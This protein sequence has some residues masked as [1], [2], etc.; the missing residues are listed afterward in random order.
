MI[1]NVVKG[2]DMAGLVRYLVGPG[3]ANEHTH[4]H[5]IGGDGFV[6]AWHGAEEL[7]RAAAGELAAYLEEPRL[8]YGTEIRSRQ[9]RQ[10]PE[11]GDREPV[12]NE[13]GVQDYRNVHVW[14]C[15][16]SLPAGEVLSDERWEKVTAEFMDE[17][18][19]S[20]ASGKAPA[21]WVAIHHGQSTNGNDH[22][23]IAASMVREDGTRW[24][25]R[26]QDFRRAQQVCREL[27]ARHQLAPVE[28]RQF[29]TATRAPRPVETAIAARNDRPVTAREELAIRLRAAAVAS[30]SEAEWLRRV[31]ADGVV[32]RPRFVAGST[33]VVAGYKA[34]LRTGGGEPLAFYGG[35]QI[36][37]DLSLPRV[38][39]SW[40]APSVVAADQA[41]TEWQA[42]FK[43]RRT[44]VVGREGHRLDVGDQQVAA[45]DLKR[46][47]G[48]LARTPVTE[49]TAVGRMRPGT[50]PVRWRPGPGSTPP[51][52][53]SCVRRPPSWPGPRSSAGPAV[54]PAGGPRRAR[55]G[56]PTS[57]WR[58]RRTTAARWPVRCSSRSCSPPRSR[59]ATTTGPPGTWLRPRP[60]TP[61]WCNGWKPSP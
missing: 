14:H 12:L 50:R 31:Q 48:G 56:P 51:M 36:S 61:R 34:A 11:T 46:F 26:F 27:E 43:G 55:W 35:G 60:C 6:Q 18:G 20:E 10:N 38:R 30:V 54:S 47:T 9:W 45:D 23:H 37:R 7:D 57:C 5:V 39:E 3:R 13:A 49:P 21:R 17:M 59:S 52:R 32:I 22:V 28:G 16:L 44:G 2:A 4:P 42:A 40:P 58:P 53:S 8:T 41:S 15:S 24:D 33:D 25:G 1:P 19:F 29:E